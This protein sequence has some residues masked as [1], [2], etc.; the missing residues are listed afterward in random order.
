MSELHQSGL[1]PDADQLNA[2]VEHALPPHERERT[3]AHLA[4]CPACRSIVSLSLPPAA[5]VARPQA[6]PVRRPWFLG[7][8]LGWNL[9]WPVAVAFAALVPLI[10]Y[11][12]RTETARSRAAA[13]EIAESQPAAA[14]LAPPASAPMLADKTP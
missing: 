3:L 1:H 2:F 13:T 11:V 12:H 7:W 6:E 4:G 8:N 9:A 10:L 5:E 14:P